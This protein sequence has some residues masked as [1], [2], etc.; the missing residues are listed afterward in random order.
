MLALRLEVHKIYL[1]FKICPQE[2][3]KILDSSEKGVIY[4][5]WGSLIRSETLPISKRNAILNAIHRLNNTV[6]LWKWEND[7][8][9]E[10][11]NNVYIRKWMPQA[12]ILCHPNVK[13]FMTHG[14]LLGSSEAAYCGVPVIST[15]IHADQ[16]LNSNLMQSRGMGLVLDYNDMTEDNIYNAL[17]EVLS[18]KY[19]KSVKQISYAFKNRPMDPL[20][21]GVWWVE[22]IIKT[23]GSP[24][25]KTIGS[26][27]SWLKYF[28]VDVMIVI[29]ILL[30][31]LAWLVSHILNVVSTG[32]NVK[33]KKK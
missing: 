31:L 24:L 25:T 10:T 11:Q 5:S 16:F 20:E 14:G 6:V 13:V 3:Q 18:G 9:P 29:G 33:I 26:E 17:S 32:S 4:I 12:Q 22:H 15:P 19:Q 2:I 21:L 30:G 27:F 1:N 7:S 28:S 8:F 23:G